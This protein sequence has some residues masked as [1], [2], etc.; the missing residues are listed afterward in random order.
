VSNAWIDGQSLRTYLPSL[1]LS[2]SAPDPLCA[3][4]GRLSALDTATSRTPA[5]ASP[6]LLAMP[7]GILRAGCRRCR[8]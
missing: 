5:L 7:R 4:G 1:A 3:R 2:F 6:G 8:D